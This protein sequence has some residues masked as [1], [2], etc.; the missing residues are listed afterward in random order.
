[1]NNNKDWFRKTT[2]TEEDEKHF[3]SKLLKVRNRSMQAQYLK[4]QAGS[5]LWTKKNDL[6]NVAENLLNKLLVDYPD[7]KGEISDALKYLGDIYLFR[8]DY[9][10]AINY[11]KRSTDYEAIFPYSITNA[12]L[13]YAELV[14]K[15]EC[16]DLYDD[17]EK[18]LLDKRYASCLIFPLSKY[19][20]YSVLSIINNY[21]GEEEKAKYYAD[22]AEENVGLQQSGFVKHQSLGLVTERDKIL[23]EL[24]RK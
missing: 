5:L 19:I 9:K 12:F 11:Y 4:L 20:A 15:N 7:A 23:D 22:L 21:K 2:W 24:V 14:V 6:M 10:R 17:V 18:L 16:V 3:F 1:M 8:E 13:D